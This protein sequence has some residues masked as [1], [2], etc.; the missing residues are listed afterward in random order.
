MKLYEK[1]GMEEK[2]LEEAMR[3]GFTKE[4]VDKLSLSTGWK[5]LW[6]RVTRIKQ[7]NSPPIL[8]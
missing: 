8:K 4:L 6:R 1:A 7:K 3:S 5:R 2:Y